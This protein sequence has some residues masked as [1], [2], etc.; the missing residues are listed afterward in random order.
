MSSS[1]KTAVPINNIF[2]GKEYA[3]ICIINN[4]KNEVKN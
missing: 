4:K 2:L 3:L 1:I